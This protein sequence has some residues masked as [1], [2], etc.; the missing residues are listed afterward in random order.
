MCG[1]YGKLSSQQIDVS[2]A[3]TAADRL[4]HRGPDERK[5]RR[6]LL[7]VVP[8]LVSYLGFLRELCAALM[9]S[10]MEVH[11]A[12][13]PAPLGDEEVAA[14]ADGVHLHHIEFPRGM[15][16]VAHLRAARALNRLVEMLRPDIV[17]AHF[18]ATILTTALARTR[19]WPV[20]HATFHGVSFLAMSGWKAAIMRASE[21]WAA[22]RFDKI[23]VLSDDDRAGL[24]AASPRA[25][26]ET[27]PGF[28]MGC[29]LARFEPVPAAKRDALRGALGIE[30]AQVV[31]AFVGRFLE[32]KGFALTVRAFLQLAA[33]NPAA[34][35]LL[36][37]CRDRLHRTGL[38]AEEERAMKGSRQIIDI[39]FR[40][41]VERCLPAADVL[42]FPSRREGMPVCA[43]EALAAGVPVIT[44]DARGCREVVRDGVD[45]LVLRQR[46]VDSLCAAMEL[47]CDQRLRRQ[48]AA[49]A[50]A[51]RER[52][53][54]N[55]FIVEQVRIYETCVPAACV[56]ALLAI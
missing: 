36:I 35:L 27:L 1:I 56:G 32:F 8:R 34:R 17:H 7:I 4:G 14:P 50:A 3:E 46:N 29:D 28:G 5:H 2:I 48:W 16:P 40:N 55:R 43:M 19:C 53:D 31:F 38:S 45:G 44:C 42:V 18:S 13:S 11:V 39:G 26:V 24:R 10:G 23:W 21:T 41:D 49:R 47:A 6:S 33:I 12:C 52:F 20:A 22:Q 15:N 51:G 54:R 9:A 37:G 25:S 30:P